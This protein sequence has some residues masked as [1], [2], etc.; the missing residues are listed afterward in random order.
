M[1]GFVVVGVDG[2]GE[3][4]AALDWA[5]EEAVGRGAG[6]R[7]VLAWPDVVTPLSVL[8]AVELAH[9]QAEVT[10]REAEL[11]V[12]E[13]W[14]ELAVVAVRVP[15]DPVRALVAETAEAELLVL[16]S[17]GLGAVAGFLVGSVGQRV[18]ARSDVPVVLVREG[19][20]EG[21]EVVVGVDPYQGAA[22]VLGHA[23]AVAE[24]RGLP[25]RA[26]YAWTL[27]VAYQYA[28]IA[29]SVD[30]SGE[31]QTFAEGELARLVQPWREAHPGVTV[32][33]EVLNAR[34]AK[35]LAERAAAGAE[36]VVVG[37]RVRRSPLGA[38]LGSVAHAVL[39]HVPCPVAVVPYERTQERTPDE[40]QEA[41]DE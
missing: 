34:P 20:A 33:E 30:V 2:S 13:R 22:E 27:P 5:A 15:Q 36:L 11:R 29:A 38:H 6:L 3:S 39:H 10:L 32:V 28:G 14:P 1:S 23:F 17:R 40:T 24:R 16:G 19:R 8:G 18:L 12:R 25:V 35:V 9:R 37:R 4:L 31:M 7:V 21:G 41:G 26:V